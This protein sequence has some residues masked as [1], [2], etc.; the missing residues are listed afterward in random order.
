MTPIPAQTTDMLW[1]ASSVAEIPAES[2]SPEATMALMAPHT[3]AA[4]LLA[5]GLFFSFRHRRRPAITAYLLGVIVGVTG[6][7]STVIAKGELAPAAQATLAYA[8][9]GDNLTTVVYDD[10]GIREQSVTEGHIVYCA[11]N[12]LP[13]GRMFVLTKFS[14]GDTHQMIIDDAE[15]AALLKM[16]SGD[17]APKPGTEV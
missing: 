2:F 3:V 9:N 17:N 14:G 7:S 12:R 13:D 11:G 5:V 15:L 10:N 16:L 6:F 4:I 8:Y 1:T